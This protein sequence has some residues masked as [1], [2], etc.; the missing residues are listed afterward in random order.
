VPVNSQAGLAL[1]R[2]LRAPKKKQTFGKQKAEIYQIKNRNSKLETAKTK[3]EMRK[4]ESR[5]SIL[6]PSFLFRSFP[7]TVLLSTFLL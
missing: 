6:R 3:A 1:A 5:N 7:Y 2:D 4:V